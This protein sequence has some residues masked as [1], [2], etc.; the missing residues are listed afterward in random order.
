MKDTSACLTDEEMA[1]FARGESLPEEAER[2]A[3]HLERCSACADRW[4][5]AVAEGEGTASVPAV[6][7]HPLAAAALRVH[8]VPSPRRPMFARWTLAAAAAALM[9]FGLSFFLPSRETERRFTLPAGQAITGREES[10]RTGAGDPLCVSLPD[11]SRFRIGSATMARFEP[12]GP[13]DRTVL[14]LERGSVDAEVARAPGRVRIVAEAG[15]AVVVGTA[16]TARAFRVYEGS[17]GRGQGPEGAAVGPSPLT[18]YPFCAVLSVEVSE[19]AVDLAGPAGAVRVVPGK[20][21]ILR[22]AEPP[23]LQESRPID[24]QEAAARYG[25]EGEPSSWGNV[26]LLA[27]SWQGISSWWEALEA[28]QASPAARRVAAFLASSAAEPADAARLEDLLEEETDGN[29][30]RSLEAGLSRL[31]KGEKGTE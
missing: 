23:V 28:P 5:A 6:D 14:R 9:A 1:V 24:W 16:F 25:R 10:F 30:R 21:G 4:A 7:P 22:G 20:R 26:I 12:P 3:L 27:G 17:G 8:A 2:W 13:G 29:V 19:G 31:R 11:G 15:E 18:P